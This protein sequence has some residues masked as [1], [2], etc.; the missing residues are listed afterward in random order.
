MEVAPWSPS[1]RPDGTPLP[2]TPLPAWGTT[3]PPSSPIY[4]E[5]QSAAGFVQSSPFVAAAPVAVPFDQCMQ[6]QLMAAAAAAVP[7]VMA[8]QP[9]HI[10]P[11]VQRKTYSDRPQ[12]SWPITVEMEFGNSSAYS[13]E[14]VSLDTGSP[15]SIIS[16]ELY[17]RTQSNV[18]QGEGGVSAERRI[19]GLNG[20]SI[21]VIKTVKIQFRCAGV[22]GIGATNG[23]VTEEFALVRTLPTR[24]FGIIFRR[25]ILA[26]W[27]FCMNLRH[28]RWGRTRDASE[29]IEMFYYDRFP[30]TYDFID[31]MDRA[32]QSARQDTPTAFLVRAMFSASANPLHEIESSAEST[33]RRT[34][35]R[36][37]SAHPYVRH[38]G[39]AGN[40]TVCFNVSR[41]F[42]LW[43]FLMIFCHLTSFVQSVSVCD[44]RSPSFLGVI[45]YSDYADCSVN[46]DDYIL[47]NILVWYNAYVTKDA[48]RTFRAQ[49]SSM[50][51]KELSIDKDFW[52]STDT[53]RNTKQ[54]QVGK[55]P[56][57]ES[58]RNREL[59]GKTND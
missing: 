45:D 2:T 43:F 32:D 27:G 35:P 39:L 55:K 36:P 7:A 59:P 52:G 44:C 13:F 22:I 54:M 24:L 3:P 5:M 34:E 9:H 47:Q 38:I 48:V 37:E 28:R 56:M 29:W 11:P 8:S 30:L 19:V 40:P 4:A 20:Q 50:Y 31:N 46:N 58:R 18:Y 42:V 16:E 17:Y 53:V 57:M 51:E 15:V 41:S 23:F 33:R 10:L 1:P 25:D 26:G 14:L 6:L 21:D 12:S 49:S